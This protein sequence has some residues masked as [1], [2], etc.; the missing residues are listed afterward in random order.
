MQIRN[1]TEFAYSA[2]ND[3]VFGLALERNTRNGHVYFLDDKTY[4]SGLLSGN[5]VG[6]A[7]ASEVL[8]PRDDRRA[9][10]EGALKAGECAGFVPASRDVQRQLEDLKM[11]PHGQLGIVALYYPEPTAD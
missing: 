1:L 8:Y 2:S 10:I 7:D 9:F 11:N 6:C 5:S 4:V 3:L